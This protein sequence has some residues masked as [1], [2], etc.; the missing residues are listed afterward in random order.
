VARVVSTLKVLE[1]DGQARNPEGKEYVKDGVPITFEVLPGE[2]TLL[3]Y[4]G[5]ERKHEVA[6]PV[7][8]GGVL[9]G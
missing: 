7:T 8:T 5:R 6:T 3:V 4:A 1:V 9:G 2:H